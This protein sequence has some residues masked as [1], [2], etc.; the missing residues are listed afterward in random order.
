MRWASS[1]RRPS[2]RSRP[3][4]PRRLDPEPAVRRAASQAVLKIHPGPAVTLPLV[5]KLLRDA[6][7]AVRMRFLLSVA[8]LG[9]GAVP[10][11]RPR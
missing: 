5:K 10:G 3:S 8:D 6:D 9:K 2:R 1:A 4:W 7:P 11:L